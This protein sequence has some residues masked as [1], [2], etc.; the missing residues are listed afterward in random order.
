MKKVKKFY[1]FAFY[2]LVILII[3][4]TLF[5]EFSLATV[6]VEPAR[7]IMNA[8]DK[9]HSTG[10]IEVI[11]TGEE[12]IELKAL[13][14][15]WT[16]DKNDGLIFLE[17]GETEYSLDDLIKFN[18]RN[19]KLAPGKKQIVR[20][21]ISSPEAAEKIKERRGVVFFERETDFV[22]SETGSKVKSQVGAVIYYIPEGVKY[23]FKF[24]GLRLYNN[25][26]P[27]PQGITVRVKNEGEAHLRYYPSYKIIDSENKV[28]MENS[29]KE[30]V[31]LPGYERQISFYL[32]DRLKKGD[33]TFVLSFRLY[34]TSYKPEYQIPITIK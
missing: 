2:S 27:L 13:L 10:L 21:T 14:N 25:L 26:K 12:E 34:N 30:L 9:K 16:L 33:Y 28:V 7:I 18:P 8:L 11:N 4:L 6:R 3:C 24:N 19:F 22:D 23:D 1:S 32:E 31:I 17:A 15:D 20:F 29:F 5:S